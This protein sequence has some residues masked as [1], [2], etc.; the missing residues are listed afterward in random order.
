MFKK[1]TTKPH[2][3]KMVLRKAFHLFI[4]SEIEK[5]RHWFLFISM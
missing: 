1:L 3:R 4:E 2:A 5:V